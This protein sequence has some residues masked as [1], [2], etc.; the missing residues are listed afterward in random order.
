MKKVLGNPLLIAILV[1]LWL[2][3]HEEDGKPVPNHNVWIM[4]G[5]SQPE[6][7][8]VMEEVFQWF[9]NLSF[10]QSLG[11]CLAVSIVVSLVFH[12]KT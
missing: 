3:K 11:I 10:A 9:D 12:Y 2:I 5:E 1:F 7:I 8:T 4:E 6:R